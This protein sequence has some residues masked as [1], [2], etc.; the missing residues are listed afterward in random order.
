M[1][2]FV[3]GATGFLGGCVARQLVEA[4]HSV[5]AVVRSPANA[6]GL[7]ALG[8]QLFPG[9]V[10]DKASLQAPMT[11][12]DG[13]YHI[14]GWYKIGVRDKSEAQRVNVDG[15]RNV[16]E[17]MRDLSIPKGVYTSTVTIFSDTH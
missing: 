2:Y 6:T 12:V 1:K 10:T 17:V 7:A 3:T 14:A 13:V 9:D 15:T 16:L 5:N 4:G 11:A 8:V